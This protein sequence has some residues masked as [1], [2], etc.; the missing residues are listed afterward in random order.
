MIPRFNP[1][2]R[3]LLG[4]MLVVHVVLLVLN[5]VWMSPT[6]DEPA[7]V[8]AGIS[9]LQMGDFSLY[10]VNP[11]L[12]PMVTAVPVML[13]GYEMNFP[14]VLND[15]LS[16]NEFRLGEQFVK[17][18]GRRAVWLV[19]LGRLPI[20][21][22]S[23]L[24]AMTCFLWGSDLYGHRSGL[25]ASGLWCFSPLV[26]GH[27]AL[28]TPDAPAAALGTLACYT[29]WRW[30]KQP[31]WQQTITTGI[32][33]GLAELSKM[34]LILFY[35]LWP[36]LWII[37]RW[38]ERS[39]MTFSRWRSEGVMLI[40]RMLIGLYVINLGYLFSG[41]LVPLKE[42]VFRS[43][44]LGAIR[45]E[46]NFGNRFKDSWLG[47]LPIPLPYDYVLGID[48]QQRDFEHFWGPSYLRGQFQQQG[49]WY[50]YLYALLVKTPLGTMGLLFLTIYCRSRRILPKPAFRD[51]LVLLAPAIF[52]FVVVS[53][54]TGFSHHLRYLFPCIPLTF[55]WIGQVAQVVSIALRTTVQYELGG[56]AVVQSRPHSPSEVGRK[57]GRFAFVTQRVTAT[58]VTNPAPCRSRCL[59]HVQARCLS[60]LVVGCS[61]WTLTSSLWHYPHSLAYFN[62]L[63]GGPRRGAEHLL[64]SNIDW[65][66]DLLHLERWIRS[67]PGNEPVFLAFDNYYNPFVLEIPRIAPWPLR[68]GHKAV[69]EGKPNDNVLTIPEGYYAISANQLYEFPWPLRDRDGTQ[70]HLDLRPMEALR[71]MEPVGWVGYSIRIYTAS[72]VKAAYQASGK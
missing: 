3:L 40:A 62:E 28:L 32:I 69:L 9:H 11:P 63:A 50:Y 23:L 24:G 15:T 34:T 21:G 49:W 45:D 25:L 35:P 19:T 18:N 43:E 52:V 27:A 36:V 7:H 26:L 54:K 44:M 5:A 8:V 41:S 67:Q 64:N 38:N 68:S 66:Q 22:F 71:A 60:V 10:R 53:S 13:A 17:Q 29:F 55:V 12:I 4:F 16:R 46:A 33:L 47:E 72:Q 20:I 56:K 70:Y 59:S 31:T 6:L 1:Q 51:E 37:Y 58:P 39:T 30:L 48:H 14:E 65:G 42:Y 2:N 57:T 61:L